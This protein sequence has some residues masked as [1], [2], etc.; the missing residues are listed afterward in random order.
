MGQDSSTSD[1][2]SEESSAVAH[3]MKDPRKQEGAI[4]RAANKL[5][6]YG[7]AGDGGSSFNRQ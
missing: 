6:T 2:K 3:E 5:Q 1:E 7:L 4:G